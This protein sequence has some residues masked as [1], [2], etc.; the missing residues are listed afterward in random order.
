MAARCVVTVQKGKS[1]LRIL[2]PTQKNVHLPHNFVL[3][4]SVDIDLKGIQP[5]DQGKKNRQAHINTITY[6]NK[7]QTRENLVFN[8]NASDLPER[9]KLLLQKFLQKNK[10]VFATNL[11]ELGM[12]RSYRHKI[13]TEGTPVKMPFYRQPPHLQR[14]VDKQIQEMLDNEIIVPSQSAWFSPVILVKKKDN[15][16]RFT[17]DYRK[18]NRQTKPIYFPLPRLESVFDAIAEAKAKFFFGS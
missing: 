16:Y 10:S 12:S 11:Q 17:V 1:I 9:E 7:E 4:S 15:T 13:E 5:L 18:L 14:E 2:N 8:L 3:A 6:P